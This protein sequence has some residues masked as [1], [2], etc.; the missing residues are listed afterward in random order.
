[1]TPTAPDLRLQ[2]A[3]F[4]TAYNIALDDLKL[5]DW[6]E[7]F[8]EECL[9]RIVPRENFEADLPLST[10]RCSSKGMLADRVKG[11]QQTMMYAPRTCRR[12]LSS[13]QITSPG[14]QGLAVR[15]SFLCVQTLVDEPTTIAFAG[16]AYDR[17]EIGDKGLLLNERVCVLDT[18][19][20]PNSL[21]YPL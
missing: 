18:E 4:Y 20:I 12:Y 8:S 5:D 7:M 2:V 3:D 13:L 17:L 6:V 15:S 10:M 21:I 9:Y 19:M 1:M 14:D 16:V 11:I